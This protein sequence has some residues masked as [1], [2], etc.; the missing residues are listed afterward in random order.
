MPGCW[1]NNLQNEV[2]IHY[3]HCIR[4]VECVILCKTAFPTA[5]KGVLDCQKAHVGNRECSFY[6]LH[7]PF[8]HPKVQEELFAVTQASA[9]AS[10]LL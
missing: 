8:G 10:A 7:R 4:G 1:G 5:K 6:V 2:R 9:L 3:I